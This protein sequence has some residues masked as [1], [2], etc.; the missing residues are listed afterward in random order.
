M[1]RMQ[2]DLDEK[3]VEAASVDLG[4]RAGS[5]GWLSSPLHVAAAAAAVAVV[6]LLVGYL[7]IVLFVF[8]SEYTGPDLKRVPDLVGQ[9]YE[10]ALSSAQRVGLTVEELAAIEHAQAAGIIV[11]QEPLAGQVAE[12]G[13]PIR[14]TLSLGAGQHPLPAVVG[15]QHEQAEVALVQAGYKT[16]LLWIDADADVRQVVATRPPPGTLLAPAESVSIVISS[17]SRVVRVPDLVDR[18]LVE[19]RAAL[20]RLGLEVGDISEDSLT[21][22]GPGTVLSQAPTA[23]SLVARGTRVALEVAIRP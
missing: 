22:A 2:R 8:P 17:G 20:E 19:A 13:S 3:P 4:E 9:M 11:A 5:R 1:V 16:E 7:A 18:S 6:G 21:S 10:E 12:A 15:M 23:G 14:V